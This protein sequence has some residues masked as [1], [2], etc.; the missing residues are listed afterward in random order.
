VLS[1]VCQRFYTTSEVAV[2]K[3]I[4]KETA[5]APTHALAYPTL[6]GLCH[7]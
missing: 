5:C 4:T 3:M 1:Y 2:F 6:A 7:S